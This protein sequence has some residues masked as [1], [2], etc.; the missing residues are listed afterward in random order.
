M[1]SV[2]FILLP[3]ILGFASSILRRLHVLRA[4]AA[5]GRRRERGEVLGGIPP[6]PVAIHVRLDIAGRH[7]R[8]VP[9]PIHACVHGPYLPLSRSPARSRPPH[10]THCT[11]PGPTTACTPQD[12]PHAP[13]TLCSPLRPLRVARASP[14]LGPGPRVG[15][16]PGQRAGRGGSKG[17]F[18][19]VKRGGLRGSKGLGLD[20]RVD[21]V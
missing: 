12:G 10:L 3:N 17:P 18:P 21:P 14:A 8:C 11:V 6:L 1:I 5:Q 2:L 16:H 20:P 4:A 7:C 13:V 9:L 19:R 15:T